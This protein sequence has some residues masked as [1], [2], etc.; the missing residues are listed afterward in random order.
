MS[1]EAIV[2]SVEDVHGRASGLVF[3]CV[4]EREKKAQRMR[5]AKDREDAERG[6]ASGGGEVASP[7]ASPMMVLFYFKRER[8][9]TPLLLHTKMHTQRINERRSCDEFPSHERSRR[10]G[11]RKRENKGGRER[12]KTKTKTKSKSK[13]EKHKEGR[14][15]RGRLGHAYALFLAMEKISTTGGERKKGRRK[16][17]GEALSSPLSA[18]AR[19]WREINLEE[20]ERESDREIGRERECHSLISLFIYFVIYILLEW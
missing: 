10:D 1:L 19:M 8:S 6:S 9:P 3:S 16:G 12:R 14:R 5:D 18:H 4:R 17:D 15:G 11:K 7:R 20:R 13:T 2:K